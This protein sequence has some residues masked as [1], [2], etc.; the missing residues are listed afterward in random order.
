MKAQLDGA[1]NSKAS[2]EAQRIAAE[3]DRN[4]KRRAALLESARILEQV[5][6][7]GLDG[8]VDYLKQHR[9]D[10]DVHV[11]LVDG[12]TADVKLVWGRGVRP[13]VVRT[14]HAQQNTF[15]LAMKPEGAFT[16]TSALLG[17]EFETHTGAPDPIT[18]EWVQSEAVKVITR[19]VK[20]S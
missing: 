16:V 9:T 20:P 19:S 12:H 3:A 17:E 8:L 14:T 15:R 11:Q 18:T 10:A 4:A 2:A 7:P 13:S 6:R 1:F 5:V